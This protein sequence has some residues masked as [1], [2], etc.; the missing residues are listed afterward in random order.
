MQFIP[1]SKVTL[2]PQILG[3]YKSKSRGKQKEK[4]GRVKSEQL[5]QENVICLSSYLFL[6]DM[7]ALKRAILLFEVRL[8][9]LVESVMKKGIVWDDF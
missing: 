3:I 1:N 2:R 4:G 8:G 7:L 9:C 6:E 5:Y